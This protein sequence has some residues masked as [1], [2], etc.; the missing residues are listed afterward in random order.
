MVSQYRRHTKLH[1]VTAQK[2]YLTTW[3]HSTEDIPNYTVSQARRHAK[4]HGVTGQPEDTRLHDVTEDTP[5]YTVSQAGK[6]QATRCHRS[7]DIPNY[8]VSQPGRQ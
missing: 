8:T 1:G 4:L 5:N 6:K 7:E 2:T 3:C